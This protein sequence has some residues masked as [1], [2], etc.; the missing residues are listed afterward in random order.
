MIHEENSGV[1]FY[2]NPD[3]LYFNLYS[4]NKNIILNILVL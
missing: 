4:Q 3:M 2:F 1:C